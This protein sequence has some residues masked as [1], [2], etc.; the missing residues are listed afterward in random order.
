MDQT[1]S[2]KWTTIPSEFIPAKAA[3][4]KR[5]HGQGFRKLQGSVHEIHEVCEPVT[6]RVR[7]ARNNLTCSA[8]SFLGNEAF[9]LQIRTHRRH[10]HIAGLYATLHKERSTRIQYASPRGEAIYE[11]ATWAMP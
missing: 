4:Q 3:I 10:K 8:A 1:S 6:G 2:G 7:G 11:T 9:G 5:G